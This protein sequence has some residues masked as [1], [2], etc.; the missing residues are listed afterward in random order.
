LTPK[1]YDIS[2]YKEYIL[3]EGYDI[4]NIR[5]IVELPRKE[6]ETKPPEYDYKLIFNISIILVAVIM[7]VIIFL[8]I[9]K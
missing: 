8:K 2:N 1:S 6:P 4:L 5:E 9:K 7:A 3:D